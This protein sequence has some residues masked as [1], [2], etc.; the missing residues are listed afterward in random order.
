MPFLEKIT[1]AAFARGR[2]HCR[3]VVLPRGSREEPGAHLPLGSD[4]LHAVA[5]A[6]AAALQIPA[7]VEPA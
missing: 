5:L 3:T 4:T 2:E 6:Q 1:L 7:W